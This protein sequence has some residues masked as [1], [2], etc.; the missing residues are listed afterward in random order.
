MRPVRV[1][2]EKLTLAQVKKRDRELFW[3]A[4]PTGTRLP[5]KFAG[6]PGLSDRRC[7]ACGHIEAFHDNDGCHAGKNGR[8][9]RAVGYP[10]RQSLKELRRDG[11]ICGCRRFSH[12]TVSP[13]DSQDGNYAAQ[14]YEELRKIVRFCK[15]TAHTEAELRI[16]FPGF[17][18]WQAIDKSVVLN[19]G[20]RRQF[21]SSAT[22]IKKRADLF[23]FIGNM[24]G[25]SESTAYD[26]Y[27]RHRR[28]AGTSRPRRKP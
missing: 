27:K 15:S 12:R 28:L 2:E 20:F 18:L 19:Q 8:S 3:G 26:K 24:M 14:Y 10:G 16:E 22:G 9:Y 21:F 4:L 23:E 17:T 25:M 7:A 6:H 1:S 13:T 11:V 5:G